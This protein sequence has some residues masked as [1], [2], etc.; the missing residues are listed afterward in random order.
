MPR[1]FGPPF[2]LIRR[3]YS[4][5]STVGLYYM[6]LNSTGTDWRALAYHEISL[7][8]IIS[9]DFASVQGIKFSKTE[10]V[11]VNLRSFFNRLGTQE[12]VGLQ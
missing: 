1:G 12:Q 2:S 10:E 3:L 5:L 11:L 4:Q 7:Q 8:S 9:A 6:F